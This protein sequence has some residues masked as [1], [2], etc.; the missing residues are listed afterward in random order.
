MF[1]DLT[2]TMNESMAPFRDLVD[3][4]TRMLEQITE[5]Q[6]ECTRSCIEATLQQSKQI[7][8]CASPAELAE[9]QQQ[10]TQALEDTLRKASEANIKAVQQAKES[11]DQLTQDTFNAFANEKK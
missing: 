10:Y 7:P 11:F 5:Q 4:Q 8:N 2:R 3:I 9:L 1:Q 6:M